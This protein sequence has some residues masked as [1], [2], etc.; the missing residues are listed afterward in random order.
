MANSPAE[1]LGRAIFAVL[2]ERLTEGEIEDVKQAL[3][4]EIRELWPRQRQL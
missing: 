3:P 4:R 2:E 1:P